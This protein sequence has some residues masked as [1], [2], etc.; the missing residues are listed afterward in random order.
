M[1]S[2]TLLAPHPTKL[3]VGIAIYFVLVAVLAIVDT[4]PIPAIPWTVRPISSLG[5]ALLK[6]VELF[7]NEVVIYLWNG[8]TLPCANLAIFVTNA[9]AGKYGDL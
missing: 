9:A 3:Y 4:G 8:I 2:S 7:Y 5:Y 1:K 6:P